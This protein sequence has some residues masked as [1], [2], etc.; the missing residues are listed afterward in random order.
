MDFDGTLLDDNKRVSSKNRE[1]LFDCKSRGYIIVGVTGRSLDSVKN[2][3]SIDFFDY[4]VLN[5]GACLYDCANEKLTIIQCLNR[6]ICISITNEIKDVATEIDYISS[7]VYYKYHSL[8]NEIL[9]F[10]Q[11]V[12]SFEEIQD[13]IVRMN[14]FFH[15]NKETALYLDCFQKKY[16]MVN[17]FMMQDSGK[18]AQWIVVNPYGVSKLSTL[19]QLCEIC[20]SNLS[21]VIFFGDG[22]NDVDVM[23]NVGLGVSM[24]NALNE[25]RGVSKD[26]TLSNNSSGIAYYLEKLKLDNRL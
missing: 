8:T 14:V 21:E 6:D 26:V 16:P 11:Y 10:I 25:V 22:L 20:H 12:S 9:P 13:T 19:K 1:V 2:V 15:D 7:H 24:K 4:L 23:E 17:S 18:D 3:T 5:N